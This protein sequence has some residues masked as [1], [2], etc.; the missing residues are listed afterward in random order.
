M[1]SFIYIILLCCFAI[2][3]K[4]SKQYIPVISPEAVNTIKNDTLEADSDT[5]EYDIIIMDS[6]FNSWLM[7]SARP[8]GYYSQSFLENR[9]Y[10]WVVAWNQRV[11]QPFQYDPNLYMMRIDYDPNIDYGY[12]VN[13]KLYNYF[14]YFQL[15]Y[16]QQLTPG[17]IPR[18]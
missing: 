13:Y 1:R 9:N 6:G 16:N 14:V 7:S 17:I 8:E 12:Q 11:N 10:K 5:T 18:N 2:A 15:K 3:C 4:S